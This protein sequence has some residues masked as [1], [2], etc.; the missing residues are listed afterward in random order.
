VPTLSI[1][2]PTSAPPAETARPT[3]YSW[4]VFAL[5]FGLLISDYMARQVLNAVFPLLKAEWALSDTSLGALSGVVAL[6]VGLLTFPLSL[7]A[8]RWGRIRSI[9]LM[10][11][12]WSIATL[13]CGMARSYEQMFVGRLLLGLGEAA[14]GSV[15]IAVVVSVFPKSLRATL[16][17]AFMAGGL[18]GQVLG[19]GLG[20]WIADAHGWRAAFIAIALAGLAMALVYPLVVGEKRTEVLARRFGNDSDGSDR[21]RPSLKG[22]FE[23]RSLVFAYLGSGT[24]LYVAGALTAWLPTYFHNYYGLSIGAAGQRAALFLAASGAGMVLCA[25]LSDR[26]SKG[27]AAA[28]YDVAIACCLSCALTIGV[29]F[30]LAP[31][32]A[33]LGAL[34]IGAFFA[35]AS[36]GPAGAMVANLTSA[37]IHATAFATLTVAN[38]ALGLAPGPILTGRLADSWALADAL[39]ILPIAA[40]AA[41]L[42]FWIGRRTYPTDL[43]ANAS[44]TD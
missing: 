23:R 18:F 5:T 10:A 15:G 25:M 39:A 19:V 20:A 29:A 41:A 44:S 22:L 3:F 28:K 36:C 13:A 16:S 32:P 9:T 27:R 26:L 12:L 33:Q 14:Y 8:D 40:V 38:N 42:L 30:A 17:A 35:A 21:K 4:V 43:A 2:L 6:T 11:I 34:A 31:G 24:Q 37:R 7:L 1:D